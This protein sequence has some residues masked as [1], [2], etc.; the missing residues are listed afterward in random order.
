MEK[1]HAVKPVYELTIA[2]KNVTADISPFVASIEYTDRIQD[3]SDDVNIVLNDISGIWQSDWYPQQGDTLTLQIG[4]AGNLLDCGLF[5]IDEIELTADTLTV[6]A[7]ATS[8]TDSLRT[9]NSKAYEKQTLKDIAKYIADKNKLKLTGDTSNLSSIKVSRKTQYNETDL[10]F[11]AKLC[12]QYSIIFSVRGNQLIFLDPKG[13]ENA[14]TIATFTRNDLS[15]YT[16]RDKTSETFEDANIS[17][18]NSKTASVTKGTSENSDDAADD[19]LEIDD[20]VENDSQAQATAEGSL[21]EKNKDKLTGSFSTDGNPLLV[22]GANVEMLS[23]GAFSGKWTIA[24]SKHSITT[25][26][27]ITDISL[28]KGMHKKTV[29]KN[30][31]NNNTHSWYNT[32]NGIK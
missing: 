9:K 21:R 30:T 18:R 1:K 24:E 16:F 12:K 25:S 7:I 29:Q 32:L 11:L 17:V 10:A 8:I 14:D 28:L 6:K 15:R 23:F 13:I 2:G 19:T 3:E 26:G 27:Y 5:Q 22:A 4:Y 20:Y 31:D